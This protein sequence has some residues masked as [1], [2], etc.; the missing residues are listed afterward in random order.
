M[1]LDNTPANAEGYKSAT[2][3]LELMQLHEGGNIF[4]WDGNSNDPLKLIKTFVGGNAADEVTQTT[5]VPYSPY[6]VIQAVN[7]GSAGANI[8]LAQEVLSTTPAPGVPE[9]ST[10]AMLMLGFASLGF[11]G[12][13][14]GKGA[15]ALAA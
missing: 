14:K 3:S 11:A 6:F 5:D 15:T 8:V 2:L 9:P 10:W 4:T 7:Q 12:Y 1:L 13:R